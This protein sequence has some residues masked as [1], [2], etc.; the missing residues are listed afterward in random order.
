MQNTINQFREI[1]LDPYLHF[2]QSPRYFSS[3]VNSLTLSISVTVITVVMCI[4]MAYAFAKTNMRFK[5]LFGVLVTIPLIMPTFIFS[6]G[7]IIMF[8]RTGWVTHIWHEITGN[9]LLLDVHSILGIV[10]VQIFSFFPYAFWPM[11]AAFKVSDLS[12]EEASQNLGAKPWYTFSSVTMPLAVPGIVSSMLLVFTVSFSDFG[13]PIILAPNGLNLI[14]VEA[15]REMS[16]FSNWSGSAVLTIVMIIVAV[17]FFLL[18]RWMTKNKEYGT[19]SGK[20]KQQKLSN[21]KVMNRLLT[22]YTSLVLLLPV[23]VLG[24]IF[25][26]SLATTWGHRLLPNGYT[27]NNYLSVFRSSS[28]SFLNSMILAGGALTLSVLIATF[29]SYYVVRRGSAGLDL[30]SSI[31]LVIP[32][33]GLGIA[34][35]QTFNTAPIQLTGTALIL[36]IGYTIR[37]MPYMIRST[38]ATMMA[39]RKDIEEA[40]VNMGASNLLAAV[41]VI[42]PL[43]LP[44]IAAGAILVFVTVIKET[45]I[46]ILLATSSWS[47]MSLVVFQHIM[48]GEYY[49]ASAMSILIIIIVIV[50]QYVA[51]RISTQTSISES[52]S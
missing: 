48:K 26:S 9:P 13:T 46:T 14:V 43:L 31:P 4:P 8:G 52:Q 40:A 51:K 33:I 20:P 6:N 3:L 28:E 39:I 50:L 25:L 16:G 5:K 44:G 10:I 21:N 37:R 15:Y 29:V 35:I 18:Q 36:I 41:T 12:L 49:H 17:L 1:S 38:L 34:L 32:G 24:S 19:I 11:V 22:A 45:S 7:M 2:F 47:P 30:M 27:F 23:L 42:A